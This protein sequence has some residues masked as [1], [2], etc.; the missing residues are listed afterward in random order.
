MGRVR[1][2]FGE[3]HLVLWMLEWQV[4][5]GWETSACQHPENTCL[6]SEDNVYSEFSLKRQ[7][8]DTGDVK[9][10]TA[11]AIKQESSHD[12]TG[13]G[14][15][16]WA[17]GRR[18]SQ[19]PWCQMWDL[20]SSVDVLETAEQCGW[21]SWHVEP[22]WSELL[23]RKTKIRQGV[24]FGLWVTIFWPPSLKLWSVGCHLLPDER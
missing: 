20:L 4:W 3:E 7:M 11:P 23:F 19:K 15:Q 2:G 6:R 8:A 22:I 10:R 13:A 24:K 16:N 1:S 18:D 5:Q 9:D 12:E 14:E 17:P 21:V